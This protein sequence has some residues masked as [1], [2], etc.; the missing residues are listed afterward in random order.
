MPAYGAPI[1]LIPTHLPHRAS[2]WVMRTVRDVLGGNSVS[3]TLEEAA[4]PMFVQTASQEEVSMFEKRGFS[5]SH[6]LYM[7]DT[8]VVSEDRRFI[9]ENREFKC[10]SAADCTVNVSPNLIKVMALQV[11]GDIDVDIP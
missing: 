6:R 9:F 10:Y 3:W 5:V 8:V 11:E 2:K 1:I 4:V 7:A